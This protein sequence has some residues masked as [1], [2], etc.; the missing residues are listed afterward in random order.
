MLLS[1]VGIL[2]LGIGVLAHFIE[3]VDGAVLP[4]VL[5]LESQSARPPSFRVGFHGEFF[6]MIASVAFKCA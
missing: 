6:G 5:S 1:L 2:E 4:L 3:Y